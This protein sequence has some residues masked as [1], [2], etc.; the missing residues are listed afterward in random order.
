MKGVQNG[1][2]VL[3]NL[4]VLGSNQVVATGSRPSATLSAQGLARHIKACGAPSSSPA[5]CARGSVSARPLSPC[6]SLARPPERRSP[7]LCVTLAPSPCFCFHA[8]RLLFPSGG[9]VCVCV[10]GGWVGG[11]LLEEGCHDNTR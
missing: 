8:R 3:S 4:S 7:G 11:D 5:H 10:G 9:C 6:L 1:H 2:V